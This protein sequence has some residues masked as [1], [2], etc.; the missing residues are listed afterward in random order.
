MMKQDVSP[1]LSTTT[2]F[3][4]FGKFSPSS[5]AFPLGQAHRF[6]GI[7]AALFSFPEE[8]SF[9]SLLRPTGKSSCPG[10]F[11]YPPSLASLCRE[12]IRLFFIFEKEAEIAE[13]ED[14]DEG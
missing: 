3:S 12:K 10:C 13:I 1:S 4:C 11:K 2:L 5:V 9:T 8:K 6:K 14:A 7:R